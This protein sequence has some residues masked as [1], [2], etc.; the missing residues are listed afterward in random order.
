MGGGG[1]LGCR[2]CVR[3]KPLV[4]RPLTKHGHTRPQLRKPPDPRPKHAWATCSAASCRTQQLL[5]LLTACLVHFKIPK[6]YNI[7]Y[8]HRIFERVHEVLNIAK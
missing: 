1:A 2:Q 8:T 7:F 3:G 5:L 4:R 6:L